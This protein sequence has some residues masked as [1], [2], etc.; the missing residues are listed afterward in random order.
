MSGAQTIAISGVMPHITGPSWPL[1]Q[2][3]S[4]RA[5]ANSDGRTG[6]V[7]GSGLMDPQGG[8]VKH[9]ETKRNADS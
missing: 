6:R 1:C 5:A 7:E 4:D 9:V 8:D 3:S 2:E